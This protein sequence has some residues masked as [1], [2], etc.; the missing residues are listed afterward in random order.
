MKKNIYLKSPEFPYFRK[1]AIEFSWCPPGSYVH[2]SPPT[3][4]RTTID[5]DRGFWMMSTVITDW[6]VYYLYPKKSME[7]S[8]L[9]WQFQHQ[10]SEDGKQLVMY[11]IPESGLA[12]KPLKRFENHPFQL[13]RLVDIQDFCTRLTAY[14][15]RTKQIESQE[16]FDL[17]NEAEWLYASYSGVDPESNKWFFGNDVSLLPEYGWFNCHFLDTGFKSVALKKPNPW[18]FYD[19]YGNMEERVYRLKLF[20]EPNQ[21]HQKNYYDS[22]F[23]ETMKEGFVGTMDGSIDDKIEDFDSRGYSRSSGSISI[24]N[25][26]GFPYATRLVIRSI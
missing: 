3:H 7:Y 1:K 14:A 22:L 25:D 2:I 23:Q 11:Y 24:I 21:E 19:M 12:K 4:P 13:D 5:F 9:K 26:Y 16:Y 20:I 8:G 17:P 15:L 6:M 10:F 18:G